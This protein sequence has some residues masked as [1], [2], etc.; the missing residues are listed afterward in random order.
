MT[1]KKDMHGETVGLFLSVSILALLSI[2]VAHIGWLGL[3]CS[4]LFRY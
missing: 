4:S 1:A 3:G 2:E